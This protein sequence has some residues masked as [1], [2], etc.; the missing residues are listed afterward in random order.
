MRL[1][2]VSRGDDAD[3]GV[4]FEFLVDEDL[5]SQPVLSVHKDGAI[6][7]SLAEADDANATFPLQ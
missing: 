4:A 2:L 1:P 3:R 6:S 5:A 7:I